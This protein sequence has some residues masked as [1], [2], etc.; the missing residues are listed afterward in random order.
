MGVYGTAFAPR[1]LR[2]A[3]E[4]P[5]LQRG[6]GHGVGHMGQ[7]GFLGLRAVVVGQQLLQQA[8]GG[9][10][11]RLHGGMQ[12][13]YQRQ[14]VGVL[15]HGWR[16]GWGGVIEHPALAGGHMHTGHAGTRCGRAMGQRVEQRRQHAAFG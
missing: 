8:V 3:L 2:P 5:A 15:H 13:R 11:W 10:V 6:G 1:P 9:R 16:A 7:I 14:H 12:P 4:Q